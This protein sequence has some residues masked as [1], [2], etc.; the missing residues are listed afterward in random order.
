MT[1]RNEWLVGFIEIKMEEKSL[2]LILCLKM[3]TEIIKSWSMGFQTI[4]IQNLVRKL[5][6]AIEE[7][8]Y[9]ITLWMEGN[10]HTNSKPY[11]KLLKDWS[12]R[13]RP[14]TE[15]DRKKERLKNSRSKFLNSSVNE[16][17][18]EESLVSE[19]EHSASL[20]VEDFIKTWNQRKMEVSPKT[21]FESEINPEREK[22]FE[23][24]EKMQKRYAEVVESTPFD[25]M[26]E[27][28][29]SL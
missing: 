16:K 3:E 29:A 23:E 17:S 8:S 18:L 4:R 6:K 13:V 20:I 27:E 21:E 26:Y 12:N 1:E 11:Q 15:D 25:F 14:G 22:L 9:G 24:I 7:N 28:Q 19:N 2:N 10:S 5:N